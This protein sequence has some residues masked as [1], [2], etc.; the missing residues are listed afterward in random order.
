[1]DTTSKPHDTA[2]ISTSIA[3]RAAIYS[4][5]PVAKLPEPI[6][7]YVNEA[8]AAIGCDAAFIALPLLAALA[9][10]VGNTRRILIKDN[11][12]EPAL[13]WAAIVGDSGTLK[14]P[15]WS[16]AVRFLEIKQKE[17]WAGYQ[18]RLADYELE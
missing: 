16:A 13:I 18:S 8:A 9:V 11:W 3:T 6:G 7:E 1:M 17:A 2:K 12:T 4:P 14:T 10:A 5:F 15:A